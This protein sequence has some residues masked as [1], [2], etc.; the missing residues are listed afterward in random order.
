MG[1]S[2]D[3]DPPA[4]GEGSRELDFMKSVLA[5]AARAAKTLAAVV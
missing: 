2:A 3:T 4:A 1:A 5:H